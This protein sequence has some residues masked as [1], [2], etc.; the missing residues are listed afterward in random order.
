MHFGEI[1]AMQRISFGELVQNWF[2]KRISF[3]STWGQH[4]AMIRKETCFHCYSSSSFLRV[5]SG[6]AYSIPNL[7]YPSLGTQRDRPHFAHAI[8]LPLS[9]KIYSSYFSAL[10]AS[11]KSCPC[12]QKKVR[13]LFLYFLARPLFFL[14]VEFY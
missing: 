12:S 13:V 11:D 7:E 14:Q 3:F 5:C 8:P 9:L 4:S 10:R 1:T 2:I 6:V